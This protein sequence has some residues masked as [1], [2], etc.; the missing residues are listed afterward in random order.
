M[1][2][3][4]RERFV[5]MATQLLLDMGAKQDGGE[6]YPLT[7]E[8]KAGRLFLS[9]TENATDG[10][11]TVF[12]CFMDDPKAARALVPDCNPCSGKWNHHYFNDWSVEAALADVEFQLKRILP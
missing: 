5:R 8:T 11:G 2:K 7:L 9:V 4:E 1:R 10:P 3:K 12:T 6:V